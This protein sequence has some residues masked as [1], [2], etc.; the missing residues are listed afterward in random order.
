MG[1][2]IEVPSMVWV[3]AWFGSEGG[4]VLMVLPR[5]ETMPTPGAMMSGLRRPSLVGPREE[6]QIT[7]LLMLLLVLAPSAPT[8]SACLEWPGWPMVR[9]PEPSLPAENTIS[10]SSSC[11]SV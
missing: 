10:M 1:V 4:L 8:V 6:N 11:H 5:A 7:E 2:A 3:V 9:A